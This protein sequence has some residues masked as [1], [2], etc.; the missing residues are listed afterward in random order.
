MKHID[1]SNIQAILFD[2]DGTLLRS[3]GTVAQQDLNAL[4]CLARSGITTAVATGRSLY[5]FNNSPGGDLPVDYI[6]FSSGAGVVSQPGGELLYKVNI[7]SELVVNTLDY[8]QNTTFDFMLHYPVPDNHKF[9]YRRV[10]RD[11]PDFETRIER[12]RRFGKPL[13]S[14]HPDG[15]GDAAQFLAVVPQNETD[16]ALRQARTGLPGLS[17]IRST[18]PLDHKSTWIEFFHPE[19]SKGR[20]ASW[21]ASELNIDCGDT[22]AIGNDYNDED[23]LEW[24]AQ[25]FVVENAPDDLK[26]RFPQVA[27]NNNGG[28]ADAVSRWLD[29]RR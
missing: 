12:Y 3:D 17:I 20:T 1:K 28:V 6:I 7:S 29:G 27:S 25:S 11:N 14:M 18:S 15:F 4:G 9:L 16:E 19:V 23:R 10:N 22:L 8:M 13:N 2:L 5:S 24:A 21:L 26:C